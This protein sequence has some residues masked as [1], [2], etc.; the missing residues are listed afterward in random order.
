MTNNMTKNN[1]AE[2]VITGTK[3]V[4]AVSLLGVL[5]SGCMFGYG[6]YHENSVQMAIFG[7]MG[8]LCAGFFMGNAVKMKK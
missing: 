2:T 6:F 1:K 7:V 4:T 8:L 5:A 3:V